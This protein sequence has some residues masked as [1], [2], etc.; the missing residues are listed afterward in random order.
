MRL[1]ILCFTAG[2]WWLQQQAELPGS[3][4]AWAVALTG[5]AATVTRAEGVA[6]AIARQ[7]LIK[8]TC[9]ALGFSWAALCAHQR[10]ADA[11]PPEWEGRDIAV[12]GVVAGL[13]QAYDRGVR[14]EFDVEKVLTA[15]AR[16]P[17]HIVLSWWGSPARDGQPATFPALEPGERWQLTVRLKRP[18][19]TANPHGFDYEAWLF[20]RNLRATG[21]VRPRTGGH[22]LAAMVHE[23]GYWIERIRS[24]A[25]TRI[26]A[27]LADA[28]YAG[29]ITALAIGDQRAIPPEQWQTFTRTGV[30]HLMSIS[31][32]H[33]T[34]VSG[35]VF[36][37]VCGLWRRV[38]RLTLALPA[39]KAAALA[40]LCAAFIYALL[41]GFAVPAQRTVYMLA[42]VACALWLG[43]FE[44]AS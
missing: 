13:P 20:E 33:V 42:I 24:L 1:N 35:L 28:P 23:P 3:G 31:G 29:I 32:L 36:A 11:L 21:Y 16:V 34:M 22:R 43:V 18:R 6:W 40:A 15:E 14:F 8:A 37:L 2:V 17:R 41:A 38:P 9:F 27:A 4:W 10:L 30:N 12:V 39:V 19:G 25:R 5:I 26:L 44:S 7:A